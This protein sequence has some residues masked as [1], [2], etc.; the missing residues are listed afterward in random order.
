MVLKNHSFSIIL[1]LTALALTGLLFIPYISLNLNPTHRYPS[2]TVQTGY[3][4]ATP[5]EVEREYSLRSQA[6]VKCTPQ[7]EKKGQPSR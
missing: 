1:L 5:E 7:A 6:S 4:N 2:V 3:I